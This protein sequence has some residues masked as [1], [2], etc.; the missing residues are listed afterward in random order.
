MKVDK[1]AKTPSVADVEAESARH[2]PRKL[3]PVQNAILT[4]KVLAGAGVIL[5]TLWGLNQ[6]ITAAD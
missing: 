3:T 6:W 1:N 5:A 2:T 4:I